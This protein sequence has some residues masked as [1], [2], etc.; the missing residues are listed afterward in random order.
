MPKALKISGFTITDIECKN[1]GFIQDEEYKEQKRSWDAHALCRPE[2]WEGKRF[3][4]AFVCWD[5]FNE[6]D[7]DYNILGTYLY[8][9]LKHS[10][11]VA[12]DIIPGPAYLM[13][14][15]DDGI[16]DLTIADLKY[17]WE[18]SHKTWDRDR[19]NFPKMQLMMKTYIAIKIKFPEL[20]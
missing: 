3:N 6:E 5:M 1:D 7:T 16:I 20:V 9:M 18:T 10:E 8:R 14:E 15:D 12:D 13:N 17:I 19:F 11:V 4:L 2:V